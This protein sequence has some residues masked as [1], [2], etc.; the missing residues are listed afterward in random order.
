MQ[1]S[2][3]ARPCNWGLSDVELP[4][5]AA[6]R[7]K[8]GSVTFRCLCD[9]IKPSAL[10]CLPVA[11]SRAALA[12][13]SWLA[14]RTLSNCCWTQEA[15]SCEISILPSD[16]RA[17]RA[18]MSSEC[19]SDNGK[20]A[21]SRLLPSNLKASSVCVRLMVARFSVKVDSICSNLAISRALAEFCWRVCCRVEVLM[22]LDMALRS[23]RTDRLPPL[24]SFRRVQKC[25]SELPAA[26]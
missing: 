23:C 8:V 22:F 5:E 10:I 6:R 16:L 26:V 9:C 14:A 15:S 3:A 19:R 17:G 4:T 13:T 7:P 12:E 25:V 1:H 11:L 24:I 21:D 2:M 18:L 20:V